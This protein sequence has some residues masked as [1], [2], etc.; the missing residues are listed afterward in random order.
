MTVHATVRPQLNCLVVAESGD[1]TLLDSVMIP[2]LNVVHVDGTVVPATS[3]LLLRQGRRLK[4]NKAFSFVTG[5][6]SRVRV[7]AKLCNFG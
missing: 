1:A 7:E 2:R 6:S 4:R 3:L 5:S